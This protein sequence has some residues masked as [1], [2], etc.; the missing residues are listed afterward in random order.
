MTNAVE[1]NDCGLRQKRADL[2][3][4]QLA[5][6]AGCGVEL[7]QERPGGVQAAL[8]L[9]ITSLMLL[10][11]SN[12]TDFM[13]FEFEGRSQ[14]NRI[15]TGVI[16]LA[17]HG[18]WPLGALIFF[19]SVVAPLLYL[20]GMIFILLPVQLGR[21][22]RYLAPLF[23]RL[24]ALRPWSMLEVYLL[25]IFVAVIKL[26]QL[27]SIE[28]GTAFWAYVVLIFVSAASYSVLDERQVWDTVRVRT[29]E[30]ES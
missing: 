21:S 2:G 30:G 23:R 6:C 4:G 16:E 18:Y 13:T 29:L 1:C 3:P 20:S 7:Y 28:L 12:L 8:A 26:D 27:A 5:C 9:T 25:G 11:V 15:I 24:K 10:A 14:G 19:A 17:R 22:P